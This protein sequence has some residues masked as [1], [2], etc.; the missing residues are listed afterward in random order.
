MPRERL[1]EKL[2]EPIVEKLKSIFDSWYLERSQIYGGKPSDNYRPQCGLTGSIENPH[3]EVTAH[4]EFSEELNSK[5]LTIICL[6]N[7]LPR[8][9]NQTF[10]DM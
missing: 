6:S 10:L 5:N 1:E 8:N 2:Y 4:G 9:F 7:F 3:L